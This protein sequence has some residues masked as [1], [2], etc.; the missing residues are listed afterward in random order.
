MYGDE[1]V[2]ETVQVLRYKGAA[3][4]LK[5]GNQYID[6]GGRKCRRLIAQHKQRDCIPSFKQFYLFTCF[7]LVDATGERSAVA[8]VDGGETD[9]GLVSVGLVTAALGRGVGRD[10]A[11]VGRAGAGTGDGMGELRTL[12]TAPSISD[13]IIPN[14]LPKL[15]I[16]FLNASG[17]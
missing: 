9:A 15:S 12:C 11:A 5:I 13:W 17:F 10:G 14:D 8:G 3:G 16:A 6:L 1:G 7:P 2:H 4:R